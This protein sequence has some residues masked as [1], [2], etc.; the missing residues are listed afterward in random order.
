MAKRFVKAKEYTKKYKNVLLPCKWCGNKKIIIA[1]QRTVFPAKD[2]WSVCC[3]THNCDITAT[4]PSVKKAVEAW[5]AKQTTDIA[6]HKKT[7]DEIVKQIVS[8]ADK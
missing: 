8:I 5:N 6:P 2:G 3:S 7:C 1:S 4:Y